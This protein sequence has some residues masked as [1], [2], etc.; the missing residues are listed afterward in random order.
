MASLHA[1]T[2]ES[3]RGLTKRGKQCSITWDLDFQ[4]YCKF[5]KPGAVQCR[6]IARSTGC[7]CR[8]KWDLNEFGYCSFHRKITSRQCVA[9]AQN[10]GRRCQK[11][12]GI[13]RDGFCL[14]HKP[15]V[16]S[17]PLCQG[18][19]LNTST[20][21]T[22]PAKPR[23]AYCCSA[24]DPF[25]KYYSPNMFGD[26]NIRSNMENE[27]V[28][29]YKG[30]DLYHGDRLDLATRGFVEMDHILEKQCFSYTFHFITPRGYGED[31]DYLTE[32]VKEEVVNEL[33]NLCFT[34]AATNKIK[35]AA[36]WKFL[37]DSLTG[38]VGYQGN[39]TFNDYLLAENRDNMRL[40]RATTRKISGEM[41]TA[42]KF[43]Q[44][45]LAGEGE[46][47]MIEALS[48]QLQ[49]LY[50]K[51]QLHTSRSAT[52]AA[53]TKS[54]SSNAKTVDAI[55]V[56]SH[57]VATSSN[58]GGALLAPRPT[59]I[60]DSMIR[61][62]HPSNKTS[63][64]SKITDNGKLFEQ[65][66]A[67]PTN[68]SAA[69]KAKGSDIESQQCPTGTN[70]PHSGPNLVASTSIETEEEVKVLNASA[71]PFVPNAVQDSGSPRDTSN[72][73]NWSRENGKKKLHGQQDAPVRPTT[74]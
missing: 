22:K 35:G 69:N 13:D 27:V 25:L 55:G 65:V 60:T 59:Q 1:S 31:V 19:F 57:T 56:I 4:G 7:Q 52:S 21:C 9:I 39:A 38:H 73:S 72:K 64:S 24:H 6:G 61:S 20:P 5:H 2:F 37:D 63:S 36:V 46:T 16:A 40:G 32:L 17:T 18:T 44:R 58:E 70:T 14:T 67:Q 33:G 30:R 3:C 66:I 47:P 68:G 48:D 50:V 28:K 8:V 10:T 34:R 12:V 26:S 62:N 45:K 74:A 71:K 51:M 42:L 53:P 41:G 49:R 54:R 15:L 43:C 11:T 23:Y 29:Y